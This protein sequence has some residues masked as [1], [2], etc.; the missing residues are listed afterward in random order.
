MSLKKLIIIVAVIIIIIFI[1]LIALWGYDKYQEEYGAD[2]PM[3]DTPIVTAT[4]KK[5]D[6]LNDYYTVKDIVQKYYE[7]LTRAQESDYKIID[8]ETEATLSEEENDRKKAVYNM[9][10]KRY[11]QYKGITEDN[12][13][14][15]IG[16]EEEKVDISINNMLVSQQDVNMYIYVVYGTAR[17]TETNNKEDFTMLVETDRLNR[18]FKI[19]LGDYI[20]DN[21]GQM[22]EGQ[23][24]QFTADDSIDND[25][26]Y[27]AYDYRQISTED[28]MLDMF[29]KFKSNM[30][31]DLE[32]AY[33]ELDEEYKNVKFPEYQDF[34]TYRN[35]KYTDIV[36]TTI[37]QYQI[38]KFDDY[39]QYV[40]VDQRGK[41]Y[42][43]NETG[44]MDFK[45]ILDTYTIDLPQFIESYNNANDATKVALNLQKIF[46]AIND[47]DYNYVYNKLD[48]TF[49]QNNFPTLE[50][51]EEYVENN[52]YT[53]NTI[54][55]GSY[56]V[57]NNIYAYTLTISN[58]ENNTETMTKDFI[59]Q[60]GVG[61]EFVMSFNVE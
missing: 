41:Q 7:Y 24:F 45:V 28:Y 12:I 26:S 42:V 49:K 33:E 58:T 1:I 10:D 57:E 31:Y 29:N 51:F 30:M 15:I 55:E 6:V 3:E 54:S 52:F 60:L 22:Q 37:E 38:N 43:I 61:T 47:G 25:N 27:N 53:K 20:N 39:T 9:L 16:Q 36:G 23:N 35:N 5:V 14:D 46:N 4:L 21:I 32:E 40:L 18:T 19:L 2:P 11:I 13:F 34:E 44:I 56:R 48:N 8:E 17:G 50:S 59:V